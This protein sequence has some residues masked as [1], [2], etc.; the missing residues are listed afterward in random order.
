MPCFILQPQHSHGGGAGL[1]LRAGNLH[2]CGE[3]TGVVNLRDISRRNHAAGSHPY[4]SIALTIR[5]HRATPVKP[6]TQGQGLCGIVFGNHGFFY[7]QAGGHHGLAVL[8]VRSSVVSWTRVKNGVARQAVV[9]ARV[10]LGR[11]WS[12]CSTGL[13]ATA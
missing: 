11:T 6:S 9:A 4:S 12:N 8:L 2:L 1:E 5:V 13:A 3:S 7:V 10:V